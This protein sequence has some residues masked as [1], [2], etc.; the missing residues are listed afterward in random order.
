M[1]ETSNAV[2]A[3]RIATLD[4]SMSPPCSVTGSFD[5]RNAT[6]VMSWPF[7]SWLGPSTRVLA[8]I[9]CGR[10]DGEKDGVGDHRGRCR[11]HCAEDGEHGH[12]GQLDGDEAE[13]GAQPQDVPPLGVEH[14]LETA[15]D[16][17]H[18]AE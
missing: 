3:K 14:H 18:R 13:V 11:T 8:S 17:S 6:L 7:G 16:G 9:Q 15:A 2:A 5:R 1:A 4:N 12:Q 10:I